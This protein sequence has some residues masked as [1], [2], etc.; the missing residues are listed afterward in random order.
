MYLLFLTAPQG[1]DYYKTSRLSSQNA[2]KYSHFTISPSSTRLVG[3][4]ACIWRFFLTLHR[5]M[6]N[7]TTIHCLP[8]RN[9]EGDKSEMSDSENGEASEGPVGSG[10]YCIL[11]VYLI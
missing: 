4:Y 7:Q 5:Q 2:L 8:A 1:W 11:S 9:S 3:T 6:S 10:K